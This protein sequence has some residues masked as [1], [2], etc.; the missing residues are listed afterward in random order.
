MTTNAN[1][2]RAIRERHLMTQAE[3][4][5]KAQVALRTIYSI[6]KGNSC[7]MNTKRKILCAL[8]FDFSYRYLVFPS[9]KDS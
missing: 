1:L 9:L 5:R 8:D 6:E 4:A 7:H 2:V 3:L